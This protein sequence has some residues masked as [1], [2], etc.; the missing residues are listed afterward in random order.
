VFFVLD[1]W[2]E[3]EFRRRFAELNVLGKLDWPPIAR[4]KGINPVAIYDP[5]NRQAEKPIATRKIP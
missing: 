5:R 3:P 4:A 2:E 1:D